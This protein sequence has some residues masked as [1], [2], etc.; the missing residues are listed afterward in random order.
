MQTPQKHLESNPLAMR[1]LCL[2]PS[3]LNSLNIST[4]PAWITLLPQ[5]VQ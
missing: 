5:E 3:L 2:I 1:Q 4:G